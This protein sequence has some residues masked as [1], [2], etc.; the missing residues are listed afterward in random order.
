M[1]AEWKIFINDRL[2]DVAEFP[3]TYIEDDVVD[4]VLKYIDV[5]VERVDTNG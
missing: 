1:M 4:Q 5:W 2:Y 3:D